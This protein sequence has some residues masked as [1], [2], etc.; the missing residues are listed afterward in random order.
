MALKLN[1]GL[2]KKIGQPN[3]GSLGVSCHVE[4]ELD[5]SL[6]FSDLDGFHER[7]KGAFIAC[8]QAVTD[9]LSRSAGPAG[10]TEPLETLP[11]DGA[12]NHQDAVPPATARQLAY[13]RKLAG[14][15]PGLGLGR[16][17]AYCERTFAKPLVELTGPE[18]SSLIDS[19]KE[20]KSTRTSLGE[21][22]RGA[23]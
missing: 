21:A 20:I 17:D 9:E 6:L 19:L 14:G 7:V 16:L 8:R 10:G 1:V 3:Y 18:V 23:A 5:Q 2:S 15:I 11:R 12:M 22:E 4:V 13:A